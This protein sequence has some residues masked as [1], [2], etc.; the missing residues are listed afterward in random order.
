MLKAMK[1]VFADY[2]TPT[3]SE[4]DAL[5]RQLGLPKRVVQVWF[6]NARAK[7]KKAR[8]MFSKTLGH[9]FDMA[10][11]SIEGCK[12]C[13]IKYNYTMSPTAMQEHLFSKQHIDNLKLIIGDC[14]KI[15]DGHDDASSDFPVA[16]G[17]PIPPTMLFN[18]HSTAPVFP[19]SI[20][21]NNSTAGNNANPSTSTDSSSAA[22]NLLQQLQMLQTMTSSGQM[23]LTL[24]ELLRGDMNQVSPVDM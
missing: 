21:D 19:S 3:M 13:M 9:E 22:N 10:T 6:Q 18:P 23:P 17:N 11:P 12:F 5:G 2:K 20:M 8:L 15:V 16:S 24:A 1:S 14:K 4:C 7:E